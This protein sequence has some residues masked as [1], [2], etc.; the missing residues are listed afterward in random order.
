MS[1]QKSEGLPTIGVSGYRVHTVD[2]GWGK[3][4]AK[5]LT[6][7]RVATKALTVLAVHLVYARVEQGLQGLSKYNENYPLACG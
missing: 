4:Q 3:G 7:T 1:R 2:K 5:V 6:T